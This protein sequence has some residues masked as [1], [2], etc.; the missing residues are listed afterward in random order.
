LTQNSEQS[1]NIQ[2]LTTSSAVEALKAANRYIPAYYSGIA[3][4]ENHNP[5]NVD[6]LSRT[7]SVLSN[8]GNNLEPL[9]FNFHQISHSKPTNQTGWGLSMNY[10]SS[11]L[12]SA[13]ALKAQL[14]S[15]VS[16]YVLST[17]DYLLASQLPDGGWATSQSSTSDYWITA[18][19]VNSLALVPWTLPEL[20][21]A[22]QNATTY[23]ESLPAGY[24][25]LTAAQVALALF[26]VNGQTVVVDQII[27]NLL[28][29]QL[30]N[31]S[32]ES[33]YATTSS[34]QL[35]SE[36][37]GLSS[38]GYSERISVNDQ[39][40]RVLINAQF[41]KNSFD[42]LT[43]GEIRNLTFLD[44]RNS[45]VA[46]LGGL[47]GAVNLQLLY[48]D[49]SIDLSALSHLNNLDIFVDDNSDGIRDF[50]DSDTD[51]IGDSFDNCINDFNSDQADLNSNSIGDVCDDA[52]NDGLVDASDNCPVIVNV[53]QADSNSDGIGDVCDD[54]DED[55]I[56]DA[57]D[58][59]FFISN[60]DQADLD[61]DGV[62]DACDTLVPQSTPPLNWDIGTTNLSTAW[63]SPAITHTYVDPVVISGPAQ[64]GGYPGVVELKNV[65]PSG[66]DIRFKPWNYLGSVDAMV[67]NTSFL[68]LDSGRYLIDD[69]T[70]WEV[71]KI[72]LSGWSNFR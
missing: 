59:C 41:G 43:L 27:T 53:D 35:L 47:E 51:G 54:T 30:G 64:S 48:V 50:I 49:S 58:N 22:L 21:I 70:I 10:Y 23:L 66:F 15:G 61:S 71:G 37:L 67:S 44:L 42:G 39:T 8:H 1:Q 60:P 69:G 36:V 6:F 32:W 5:K 3:W 24:S 28:A 56:S 40:L 46:K 26:K 11:P 20:N 13:L 52:D 31:G 9:L 25:S 63:L 33:L 65:T 4:L 62:G 34:L 2:H 38:V 7:I 55:G 57:L 18:Q 68:M 17:T 14:D 12:D 72:E 19:V 16:S 29:S 45:G